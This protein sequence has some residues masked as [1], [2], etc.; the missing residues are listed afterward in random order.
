MRKFDIKLDR[1]K[2]DSTVKEIESGSP[3]QFLVSLRELAL[4]EDESSLV[5]EIARRGEMSLTQL[6]AVMGADSEV[7]RILAK[8]LSRGYLI[9]RETPQ[10][11]LY[12]LSQKLNSPEPITSSEATEIR[13][14]WTEAGQKGFLESYIRALYQASGADGLKIV[15]RIMEEKGTNLADQI[16]EVKGQGPK[17]AGLRYVELMKAL[18][19][20]LEV[21]Y[22]GDDQIR[23]RIG[24]CAYNFQS[25]EEA[26]CQAVSR[27]DEVI[28]TSLG[29]TIS[30]ISSRA[31]GDAYCEGA[32]T[33]HGAGT[34]ET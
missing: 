6:R 4:L 10:G 25:G 34:H 27:L 32:V 28:L 33:N 8:L 18:G 9:E 3:F 1:T 15:A 20:P 14:K 23:F 7:D 26:L 29:C 5:F 30:F 22:I 11:K 31:R 16:S 13:R 21:V 19:A 24:K 2:V 17:L 12:S